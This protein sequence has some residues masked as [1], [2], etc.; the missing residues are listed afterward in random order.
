MKVSFYE[1]LPELTDHKLLAVI[2]EFN[3]H[4]LQEIMD[5]DLL[6]YGSIIQLDDKLLISFN[7]E[8]LFMFYLLKWL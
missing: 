3:D 1:E 2:T 8:E 5:V 6:G 4:E 7:G